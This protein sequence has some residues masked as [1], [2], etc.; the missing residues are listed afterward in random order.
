MIMSKSELERLFDASPD[1]KE[2]AALIDE[3][4]AKVL[5]YYLACPN[6]ALGYK[7]IDEKFGLPYGTSEAWSRKEGWALLRQDKRDNEAAEKFKRAGSPKEA[8]FKTIEVAKSS[9]VFLKKG[10]LV[11]P[12][13]R[14]S[15]LWSTLIFWKSLTELNKRRLS[16][17]A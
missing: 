8:T 13:L 17:L 11:E 6:K 2:E 4:K 15:F 10:C 5:E 7:R 12:A 16:V 14:Q 3:R 1:T 9:R